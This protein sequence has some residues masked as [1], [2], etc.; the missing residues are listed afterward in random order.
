MFFVTG[1]LLKGML[2]KGRPVC[3]DDLQKKELHN[4]HRLL[5]CYFYDELKHW[6]EINDLKPT[7]RLEK[8]GP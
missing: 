8:Q 2:K 3:A 7:D 6:T 4:S 1:K 5:F